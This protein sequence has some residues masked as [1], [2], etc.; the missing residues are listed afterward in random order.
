MDT[1]EI[2]ESVT[3]IFND[4]PMF[5]D[6]CAKCDGKQMTTKDNQANKKRS[7]GSYLYITV[8]FKKEK[9]MS[10]PQSRSLVKMVLTIFVENTTLN[11][12]HAIDIKVF[13]TQVPKVL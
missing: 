11:T 7:N 12:S 3:I 4:I 8:N 5:S 13:I 1:C 2:F 9:I 10:S 6:I